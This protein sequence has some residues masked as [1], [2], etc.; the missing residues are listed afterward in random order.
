MRAKAYPGENPD[1]LKTPD[2]I[3]DVFLKLALPDCTHHGETLLAQP[4]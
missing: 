4:G 3:T 2:E 1:T